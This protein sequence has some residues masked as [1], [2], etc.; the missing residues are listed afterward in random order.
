[1]KRREFLALLGSAMLAQPLTAQARQTEG[2]DSANTIAHFRAT[3]RIRRHLSNDAMKTLVP[4]GLNVGE[5]VPNTMHLL[6]FARAV[7]KKIPAIRPYLYALLQGQVL[8]VDPK[9]R[10]IVTVVSE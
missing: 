7:R 10:K 6:S 2:A 3:S 1:M 9:T 8:I 4:A 5:V